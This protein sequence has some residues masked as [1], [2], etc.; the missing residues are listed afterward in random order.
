MYFLCKGGECLDL[1]QAATVLI[2]DRDLRTLGDGGFVEDLSSYFQNAQEFDREKN[3]SKNK[4]L[5][6]E[7]LNILNTID[8]ALNEDWNKS[9]SKVTQKDLMKAMKS[10][11]RVTAEITPKKSN[12]KKTGLGSKHVPTALWESFGGDPTIW[13]ESLFF[14]SKPTD[15]SKLGSQMAS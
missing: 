2:G 3:D 9:L 14:L 15:I 11:T 5:I 12:K 10:E 7:A 6:M 13:F 4:Q 8:V 1:L